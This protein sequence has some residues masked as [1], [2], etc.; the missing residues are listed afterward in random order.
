[1]R[2]NRPARSIVLTE[3]GHRTADALK[4]IEKGVEVSLDLYYSRVMLTK[5]RE[6]LYQYPPVTSP[7][8][9]VDVLMRTIAAYGQTDRE[10][11]AVLALDAKNQPT[12]ITISATG[13][14]RTCEVQMAPILRFCLL[15]NAVQ[16]VAAHNHPSGDPL[17]SSDDKRL[18]TALS[19]ACDIVGLTLLDH[20][21]LG[22]HPRFYS[23]KEHMEY[24]FEKSPV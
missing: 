6:P 8:V 18:T 9:V 19:V 13:G 17:P 20:I 10:Q 2:H 7:A 24:L 15:T 12:G 22:D 3:K 23:M 5:E 1:M 4:R 14:T 16:V 11:F 21:V